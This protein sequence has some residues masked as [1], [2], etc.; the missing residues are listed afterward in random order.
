MVRTVVGIFKLRGRSHMQISNLRKIFA[1]DG[2][3]VVWKV[4]SVHR[5]APSLIISD[6]LTD[7][8]LSDADK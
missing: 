4:Q 3:T 5:L 7:N 6:L 1:H 2:Y 8:L